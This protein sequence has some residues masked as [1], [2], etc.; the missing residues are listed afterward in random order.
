MQ[1]YEMLS[2]YYEELFPVS[3]AVV[4]MVEDNTPKNGKV[5]DVGAAKG[6]LVKILVDKGYDALGLEYVPELIGYKERTTIGDM[7][8]LAF[9]DETFDTVVC[10]GNTLV[11]SKTPNKVLAEFSRVLKRGGKVVLQILN[12]DRIMQ[13]RPLSLPLIKTDNVIFEREY[14]YF[15]DNIK[16]KGAL[17]SEQ[18]KLES[19]VD[20]YPLEHPYLCNYMCSNDFG[21]I[22]AYGGFDK[23]LYK[24]NESYALVV[25]AEKI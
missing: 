14:E 19:S 18:I 11:H 9:A 17:S 25:M 10:T 24:Q 1:F 20:L 23:S 5:L 8:Q 3:D 22:Q 2:G 6:E 21:H 12:Y 4:K 16:F 7:H 13:V 15:D